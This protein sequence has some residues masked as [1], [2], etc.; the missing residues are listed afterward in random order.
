MMQKSHS[1]TLDAW[2]TAKQPNSGE[3]RICTVGEVTTLISRLLDVPDLNGIWVR[4]EITNY[5]HH[6][7]GHRYFSLSD[8][9]SEK[10][11]ILDCKMWKGYARYTRFTPQ[12]GQMVEAYGTIENYAPH[13]AYSLIVTQMR[14]TGIG[15]KFILIEKWKRELQEEGLFSEERKKDLPLYPER[16]GVITSSTGAVLHD[17]KNV[18]ACRYPVEIILSPTAVQGEG[19]HT[20][21]IQALHNL[22]KRV[23]V[24]IIARGGG[25]FED[26]F[27]F[28]HPDLIRAVAGCVTPIVSAIGHEVDIT[29]TDLVADRRASTPSHAAEICVPDRKQELHTLKMQKRILNH[30]L[31]KQYEDAYYHLNTLRERLTLHGMKQM[32]NEKQQ[33][34]VDISDRMDR[35]QNMQITGR[36][37]AVREIHA[38]ILAKSPVR[39]LM[40]EIPERRNYLYAQSERLIM[41]QNRRIKERE[42]ELASISN[43]LFHMNPKALFSR[44]YSIVQKGEE[45]IRSISAIEKKDSVRLYFADGTADATIQMVRPH[46]KI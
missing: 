40:Y 22:D 32:L 15:E 17:I 46:E 43:L 35:S 11:A 18:I 28:N 26:L 19:V 39:I 12:N 5:N 37:M 33:E 10:T 44:G 23:D 29:L 30:H 2:T 27:P 38:Q 4:G 9:E 21:I 42:T 34:L 1:T 20:E 13:G 31:M 45:I 41:S 8:V 6:R 3:S 25:S 14:P 16:V 36:R 24:I 7:S